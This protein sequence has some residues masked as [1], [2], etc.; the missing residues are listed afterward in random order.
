MAFD[1]L[2][3]ARI[4]VFAVWEM[5]SEQVD[6]AAVDSVLEAHGWNRTYEGIDLPRGTACRCETQTSARPM[7]AHAELRALLEP[8]AGPLVHLVL[9]NCLEGDLAALKRDGQSELPSLL[10][11]HKLRLLEQ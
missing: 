3:N 5:A 1:A 4:V 2:E 8:F 6:R 9:A 7:T 10:R 11:P